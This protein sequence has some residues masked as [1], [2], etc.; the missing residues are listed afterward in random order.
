V[1]GDVADRSVELG[2][3]LCRRSQRALAG[4]KAMTLY[5][6]VAILELC[7]S[8][9]HYLVDAAE[10]NNSFLLVIEKC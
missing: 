1:G 6:V 10:I 2:C 3:E 5:L 7:Q 4:L 8:V 9:G